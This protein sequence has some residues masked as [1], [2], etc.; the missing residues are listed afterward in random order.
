MKMLGFFISCEPEIEELLDV[1]LLSA[2][3]A[4]GRVS[5]GYRY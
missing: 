1:R 4:S 5:L 3:F 2:F